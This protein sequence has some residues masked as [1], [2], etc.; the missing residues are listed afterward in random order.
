MHTPFRPLRHLLTVVAMTLG[1]SLPAQTAGRETRPEG[2]E[3]LVNIR[4]QNDIRLFAV[5][6]SL[7]A[8]GFDHE[9]AGRAMSDVRLEVRR[10]LEGLDP[11]LLGR[12]KLFYDQH[13]A[14]TLQDQPQAAY[15]SLS[16]LLSGPPEFKLETDQS[17]LPEDVR[18]VQG[19]EKLAAE[20]FQKARLAE[21]WEYHRARYERELLAY[22][23]ILRDVVQQ[24]LRYFRIPARIVLDRQIILTADLL[25]VKDIVNA[26][27]LEKTYYIVV[28]PS[29][30][31]EN[32]ARQLEHEYLHFLIDPL[33]TKYSSSL[34]GHDAILDLAQRQPQIRREY[35]N[36]L[37]LVIAESLIESIQLRMHPLDSTAANQAQLAKLFRQ[38]LVLA[39]YFHRGLEG[40]EKSEL[41]QLPAYFDTLFLGVRDSVARED[42][43]TVEAIELEARRAEEE[44]QQTQAARDSQGKARSLFKEASELMS[45]EEYPAA[46]EKLQETLRLDPEYDNAYFYLGQIALRERALEEALENYRRASDSPRVQPWVQARSRLSM[47]RILAH[48][49][50]F[51]AARLLFEQVAAMP[52][53]LKGAQDEA[54]EAMTRL[55][56]KP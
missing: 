42:L 38:G 26:R 48:K 10:Q 40:F 8:A 11:E 45:R 55:P 7:N 41:I 39:P 28:G 4:F 13:L 34:Q 51:E 46:K 21:L 33:I 36:R 18:R 25:D 16:L 52:G 29:D 23:P 19:F 35:Q 37:L 1:T 24:T 5:M 44:R 2:V 54:R 32:N 47:A 17:N 12:L 56:P 53:D 50:D 9:T 30:E 49:Q 43:K 6:A 27:N 31:P 14:E 22:Q 3:N 15:T 20:V